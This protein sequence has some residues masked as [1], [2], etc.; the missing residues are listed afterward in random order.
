MSST[1]K[2]GSVSVVG[3]C[4]SI[5]PA[6]YTRHAVKN[7][8]SPCLSSNDN[9][10][11]TNQGLTRFFIDDHSFNLSFGNCFRTKEG[12][13]YAATQKKIIFFHSG[14]SSQNRTSS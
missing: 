7:R 14:F 12:K 10:I 8:V 11:G 2:N 4:G 9:D 5:R 3:I 6:S 1:K 13:Q